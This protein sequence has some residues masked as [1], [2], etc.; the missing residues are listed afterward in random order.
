MLARPILRILDREMHDADVLSERA[1][2]AYDHEWKKNSRA[3][4]KDPYSPKFLP[5][6]IAELYHEFKEYQARTALL[7]QLIL[8]FEV[9]TAKTLE[10]MEKFGKGKNVAKELRMRITS[11]VLRSGALE[12]E[13]ERV[14]A[15]D[16][17]QSRLKPLLYVG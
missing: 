17:E 15:K 14:L 4:R 9:S 3:F 11:E 6:I 2:K 1:K 12:K 10:D 16:L 7:L 13:L 5:M 8:K